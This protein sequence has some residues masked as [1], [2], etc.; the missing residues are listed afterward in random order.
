MGSVLNRPRPSRPEKTLITVAHSLVRSD[1]AITVPHSAR[2]TRGLAPSL[3][4]LGRNLSFNQVAILN[5]QKR[6]TSARQ[7]QISRYQRLID[8][9]AV[10]H[11]R[12]RLL[13]LAAVKY[14]RRI[15]PPPNKTPNTA[16]MPETPTPAP[17]ISNAAAWDLEFHCHALEMHQP[18]M[19]TSHICSFEFFSKWADSVEL[20]ARRT[21]FTGVEYDDRII[22]I[23]WIHLDLKGIEFFETYATTICTELK[24]DANA[25]QHFA[26]S[27]FPPSSF[28]PLTWSMMK[29]K[30]KDHYL[31]PLS[32]VI[33]VTELLD[34]Q[35]GRGLSGTYAYNTRFRQL[36]DICKFSMEDAQQGSLL[37]KIYRKQLNEKESMALASSR[38]GFDGKPFSVEDL[39]HLVEGVAMRDYLGRRERLADNPSANSALSDYTAVITAD[40][41]CNRYGGKGHFENVCTTP[42]EFAAQ[43]GLSK[44]EAGRQGGRGNRRGG[45]PR[46]RQVTAI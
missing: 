36:A 4:M 29:E 23:A 27:S 41:R 26:A 45:R 40:S 12:R 16:G 25:S 9:V 6:P 34:L 21:R 18:L 35:R 28:K 22:K 15:P 37:W 19:L 24:R 30:L 42:S 44:P 20:Y 3:Y 13:L 43:S 14:R 5:P 17:P 31:S 1:V 2:L 7:K 39:I 8:I 32:Y 33:T 46:P 38:P 10:K 11:R